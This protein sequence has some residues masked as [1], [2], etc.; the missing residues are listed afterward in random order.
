MVDHVAGNRFSRFWG[1]SGVTPPFENE[2]GEPIFPV[3]AD[4]TPIK[5]WLTDLQLDLGAEC[6]NKQPSAFDEALE[7]SQNESRIP[8]VSEICENA[9]EDWTEDENSDSH[10][11]TPSVTEDTK[12]VL[13][14]VA[15]NVDNDISNICGALL[16]K[17]KFGDTT[18]DVVDMLRPTW[19]GALEPQAMSHVWCDVE[20]PVRLWDQY[21]NLPMYQRDGKKDVTLSG[22]TDSNIKH[23]AYVVVDEVLQGYHLHPDGFGIGAPSPDAVDPRRAFREYAAELR[24]AAGQIREQQLSEDM[25]L[26]VEKLPIFND[27]VAAVDGRAGLQF[28]CPLWKSCG[29]SLPWQSGRA[30]GGEAPPTSNKATL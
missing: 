27:I 25:D 10:S 22:L 13:S 8:N 18:P 29:L 14:S 5:W 24:D 19:A 1:R 28:P 4:G 2:N 11:D 3:D 20:D 6:L 30:W 15:E 12:N 17:D 7:P 9:E 21:L 16:S 26:S 23:E